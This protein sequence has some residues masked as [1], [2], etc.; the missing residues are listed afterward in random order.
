MVIAEKN[1]QPRIAARKGTYD[2]H[3]SAP[4]HEGMGMKGEIRIL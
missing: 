4:F 1:G 3:C 2:L